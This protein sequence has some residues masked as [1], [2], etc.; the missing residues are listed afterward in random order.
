[1][2][3]HVDLPVILDGLILLVIDVPIST[4]Q[5]GS[6]S[7]SESDF[8]PDR[9]FTLRKERQILGPTACGLGRT[10]CFSFC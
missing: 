9:G 10:I 1:M 8:F 4:V 2:N 6:A 5:G 7:C 3:L